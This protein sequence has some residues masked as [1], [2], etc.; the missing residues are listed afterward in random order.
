MKLTRLIAAVLIAGLGGAVRGEVTHFTFP[1]PGHPNWGQAIQNKVYDLNQKTPK[2]IAWGV[3]GRFAGIDPMVPL[4][5]HKYGIEIKFIYEDGTYNW[6]EPTRKFTVKNPDWQHFCGIYMPSRPVKQV[7]FH[8]RLATDGEAWYDGVTLFE[9]PDAPAREDCRVLQKDGEITIANAYLSCTILPDEGATVPRL[10]DRRTGVNYAGEL[11]HRRLLLDKLRS[12]GECYRRQW[13]AEVKKADRDEATVEFRLSGVGG[14]TYLDVIRRMTLTRDAAAL[15]VRHDWHN[16]PASMGDMVVEPWVV[17]GLSPHGSRNQGLYYPTAKG[18]VSIGPGGGAVKHRDVIGGWYAAHGEKVPTVVF[19]FDWS[20]YAETWLFLAGDNNMMSDVISQPVKIPAGG[21]ASSP[22]AFFP[23]FGIKKPDGVENGIAAALEMSDG[24]LS[25]RFDA[26]KEGVFNIELEA[27]LAGGKR[28]VRRGMVFLSPD[29]TATF[30]TDIPR[31]G[32]E[33]FAVKAYSGGEL[34]FEAERAF[35]PDYTY[36]PKRQKAKPAEVKPFELTLGRDFVT[37]HAE[38][39][40][41]YAGGKPRVLF[42]TS[43]HQAREIVEL[44]ERIDIEPRTIRLAFSENTTSWAMIEQFGTYKYRDMNISLKKELYGKFDVIVVSGNLLDVVDKENRATIERRVAEGAGFIRIGPKLPELKGDEAARKWIAGNVAPELL[45]FKAGNLRAAAVGSHREVML[46]YEGRMGLT[47]FVPYSGRIPPFRYQDYSLGV[48]GRAILW[49][50]KMDVA[51]PPDAK[52]SEEI[53]PVEPGFKIRHTF[54]KGSKGVYDWKAETLHEKKPAEFKSFVLDRAN[55]TFKIGEAVKGKVGLTGGA[56]RVELT[57]GFGRLLAAADGVT[58]AFSLPIPEART[59]MLFVDAYLMLGNGEWGTGNGNTTNYQLPTNVVDV[60]HAK[61]VCARPWKRAEYPLC[62][63]EG[64]ITYSY[65]KQYLLKP[66][67]E[68]YHKLGIDLIRF[69]CSSRPDSYLHMLPYGFDLDFSIYDTRIGAAFFPKFADP[70]AKTKD[71]KYLC[72]QPCLHDPEYRKVLDTRTRANVERIAR[73]CPVTCDC[74]DENTLTRWGTPFDF[75]FSEHTLKAFR[76]WLKEQYGD[77]ATLNAAWRTDFAAWDAVTPDTTEEARERAKRTGVKSY[78]AWADHRRFMELTFCETIDR[79]GRILHEKLPDV[80]LDMSGT[81]APNGWTGMDMWLISKSVGEPAAYARGYLG[82]LVRSFGRPFVKPWI[83]YGILPKATAL[84]SW[85]YAFRF[86]DAGMYFW[87]CFNFL[88]PDYSP[89]PTAVQ[90]GKTG[91]ELR[92]GTARL[93]RSLESRHKVLIHYSYAS[94][95]AAQVEDRYQNFMKCNEKWLR[96]LASEQTATG[97]IPV[98][99]P[100]VPLRV[101]R[102]D[103]GG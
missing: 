100:A 103:R 102:R 39:A 2:R 87:T 16:Q 72:R 25:A 34:V 94:I 95:H 55:E 60:R 17:N 38:F 54:W 4:S 79:V 1:V 78:A 90:Y 68:L 81:Q 46:D 18:I 75:C 80:P 33:W 76:E 43:I 47:P 88:L 63:S 31:E 101:V 5:H 97:A 40:K 12:G 92:R 24:R 93:L 13:K 62:I 57:D 3:S 56:A 6:F 51:P 42:I 30:P 91:E 89:T 45:P 71:K 99:L 67:M 86:L 98:P 61:V 41:P 85:D 22:S 20:H 53:V 83:G 50:A 37:P 27:H 10:I 74:G 96:D 26:V 32:V 64:W 15:E 48:V 19:Q 21:T 66:R 23:L 70:Y 73:F 7:S 49:A 58:G 69:W 35:T 36:R 52:A 11:P 84:A 9:L 77:L 28:E 65:E 59:G 82:D 44:C 29:A 8:Y 14:Q